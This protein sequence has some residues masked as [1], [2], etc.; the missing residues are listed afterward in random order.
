MNVFQNLGNNVTKEQIDQIAKTGTVPSHL[1][2]VEDKQWTAIITFDV[3]HEVWSMTSD[4]PIYGE[5]IVEES[6]REMYDHLMTYIYE[7]SDQYP[8]DFKKSK[9]IPEGVPIDKGLSLYN[10]IKICVK[11]YNEDFDWEW[12]NNVANVDDSSD[13]P[14]YVPLKD[15]QATGMGGNAGTMLKEE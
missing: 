3:D 14:H 11:E 15:A 9:I 7:C 12:F 2:S 6:R 1:K 4:T 13:T 5:V 8:I 10:F